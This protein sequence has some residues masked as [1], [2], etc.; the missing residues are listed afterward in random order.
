M[1]ERELD[2]KQ[3]LARITAAQ[4][5]ATK[6][7]RAAKVQQSTVDKDL[8]VLK[9]FFNWCMDRGLA[10]SNPVRKVK[11]FHASNERIRYGDA[12]LAVE[13]RRRL[14]DI[15]AS[16]QLLAPMTGRTTS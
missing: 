11:F 13:I 8:G 16:I 12:P 3:L 1:W 6:L 14:S 5:E 9:A 15:I 2:P 4:I 7:R 10:A